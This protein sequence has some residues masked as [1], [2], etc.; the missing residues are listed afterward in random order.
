[1]AAYRDRSPED[2]RDISVVRFAEG[3]WSAPR[4]VHRDEWKIAGCPVNGPALAVSDSLVALAWFTM[5]GGVDPT[6]N[7]VFSHNSGQSF[8][9]PVR[10]D[11]HHAEGR[12]DLAWLADG[13]ALVVWLESSDS[14]STL[15]ARKV[16]PAAVADSA[17]L[18]TTLE[19]GRSSGIPT[20]ASS[21]GTTLVAWTEAGD[22]TFVRAARI[23]P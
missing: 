4:L 19:P 1:L 6:V 15:W 23:N 5:S 13:H 9:K 10:V 17:I 12:V 11:R 22:T 18:V 16:S 7:V 14:A 20:V 8:R 3:V 2:V 21:G